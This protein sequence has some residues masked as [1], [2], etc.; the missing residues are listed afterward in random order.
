M[1]T[2][3]TNLDAIFYI[4]DFD[5]FIELNKHW[6]HGK[7]PYNDNNPDHKSTVAAWK[8][9]NTKYYNNAI[10]VWTRRDVLKRNTAKDN[11]L[12]YL[13]IF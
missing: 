6:S 5:F 7:E 10:D 8:Q 11:N 13:E 2:S 1:R 12:N 9:K 3:A 4:K